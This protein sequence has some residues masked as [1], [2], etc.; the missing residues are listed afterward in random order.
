MAN[1]LGTLF[2]DS[3]RRA[4]DILRSK[5][6][7]NIVA[8]Y[9]VQGMSYL[10]PIAVLPHLLRALGP[11]AFGAVIFAQSVTAYLKI[12]TDF[13][14]AFSATRDISISREDRVETGRIF[15]STLFAKAGLLVSGICVLSGLVLS[16][17]TLRMHATLIAV[18][19]TSAVGWT[20]MPQW[21]YQGQESMKFM[22]AVQAATRVLFYGCLFLL[23]RN[24]HDVLSA[25]ALL[26]APALVSAAICLGAIP[27]VLPVKWVR[28]SVKD[29]WAA[30][31]SSWHL[32]LSGAAT[33]L[34]LNTTV[35]IIG[36][37]SGV[38]Q[39]ALYGI[40]NR[41]ALAVFGILSPI[42]QALFPR[43]SLLF[44]KSHKEAKQFLKRVMGIFLLLASAMTISIFVF[45][46]AIISMFGGDKY[47]GAVNVLRVMAI[48]PFLLALATI[49][50]QFIMINVGLTRQLSRIYVAAGV[51]S[52]LLSWPLAKLLG[53]LGGA[54]SLIAVEFIGPVLMFWVIWRSQVW[55]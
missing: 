42:S 24:S 45:A 4:R 40:A 9:V 2:L 21:Y 15:W 44:S 38:Y 10:A 8:L 29:I 28:P 41:V 50:S 34:Y 5:L 33:S 20:F 19:S 26:S 35:F 30:L 6:G 46:S 48:L 14:F 3:W 11:S 32:F 39:V 22:A 12:W 43:M 53:A 23:V 47:A 7:T 16:V 17:T 54:L 1:A 37:V 55:C 18:S 52:L 25:A 51:I 36:L 27:R 49:L 13:G 31:A